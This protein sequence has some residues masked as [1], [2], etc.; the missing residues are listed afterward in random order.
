M[1]VA[2][3]TVS[4]KAGERGAIVGG[5]TFV[6]RW[7]I[8]WMTWE[9][10][11]K[12]S[13][14]FK[15]PSSL[16]ILTKCL[17]HHDFNLTVEIPEDRL[18]PTLPL[19][20]NYII[21]IEDLML[22]IDKRDNIIGLDIGTGVCAIYPLLGVIKNKWK[23][24]GTET[25]QRNFDLAQRNVTQNNLQHLITISK[26]PTDTLVE[27]LFTENSDLMFD[28]CMCN[29]PF[30]SNIEELCESRSVAR[31][32]PKNCF[33]GSLQELITEGGELKFIRKLIAESKTFKDKIR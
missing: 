7:L 11:G 30:Y 26:N 23:M 21:W 12:V 9:L 31:P 33:T 5:C 19:R 3:K 2:L 10:S 14:N 8:S 22:S 32:E 24:I 18:V 29:P 6:G 13:I 16:R 15:D 20:L 17:L 25:D 27:Y 4:N 28:F 1:D